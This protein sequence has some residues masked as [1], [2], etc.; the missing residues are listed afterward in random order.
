MADLVYAPPGVYVAETAAPVPN[1]NTNL[2]IPPSRVCLVGPSVGY[3]AFTE[4]IVLNGTTPTTLTQKG[5]DSTSIVVTSLANVTLTASTDYTVAQTG[6]P[7]EEAVTTVTRI[8]GGAITDGQTVYVTY[9]YSNSAFYLPFMS[10]DWDEIQTRYGAAIDSITGAVSS[11][12]SLA[13]KIAMEQGARE[14]ILVPTKSST[15][16]SVTAAQINT[17]YT[18]IESR[19]DVG[20]VVPI[21]V[22][23]SGTDIAPGD[24]NSL[25]QNLKTH[26]ET[27]SAAGHRRYGVFGLET[28]S[29]RAP[30]AFANSIAS[31]RVIFVHPQT[32]QWYNGYTNT[33]Q[34]IGG[35][36]AGA[37][38]AGMLSTRAAQEPLTRKLVHS[39]PAI[40]ARI[41][42][43]MTT[44]SKNDW[45]NS[46]VCVVEQNTDGNLWVRH[47]VTTDKTSL[48]TREIS[49]GRAKDTLISLI[50]QALDSSGLIGSPMTPD[51]PLRVR[52]IVDGALFQA[53]GTGLI[54]GYSNLAVQLDSN[55]ATQVNVKFAY[56]PAYP[57]N[58]IN[59]SFSINTVTGNQSEV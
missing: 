17:A 48:L 38:I 12:L 43:T 16:T 37:A 7:A 39:F 18:N 20:L 32:F 13:A 35:C 50:F 47:G 56:R 8:G 55:N 41:V 14:I 24:T 40:P 58:Y 3:Q 4:P 51:T 57:V 9:H 15:P 42:S 19:T 25:A 23:I 5:I 29:T 6:T 46:G 49:I 53:A 36:Y 26:V 31:G 34:E 33:T 11:P 59:V 45:S 44:S 52:G 22:S 10:S 54:V 1:V 21:G 28:G 2:G 27:M 30:S